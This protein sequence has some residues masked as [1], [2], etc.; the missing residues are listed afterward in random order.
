MKVPFDPVS[1]S[2]VLRMGLLKTLKRAFPTWAIVIP[3]AIP[4]PPISS[5]C[6]GSLT[7]DLGSAALFSPKLEFAFLGQAG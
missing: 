5:A 3:N 2:G 7:R 4:V 1:S 6:T